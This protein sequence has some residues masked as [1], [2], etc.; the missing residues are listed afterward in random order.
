MAA[1]TPSN[2]ES[3]YAA[4]DSEAGL[5]KPLLSDDATIAENAVQEAS[6]LGHTIDP[7]HS[8]GGHNCKA[9]GG[10]CTTLQTTAALLTLQLGWGL[11]LL[12]CDFARL[13][14]IPG[15]GKNG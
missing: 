14:W 3:Y 9:A 10:R 1:T 7:R 2:L 5:S 12:P 6:E 4:H 15:F 13:G 11:W 8:Q